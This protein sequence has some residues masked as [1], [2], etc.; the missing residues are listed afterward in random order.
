[1]VDLRGMFEEDII[2]MDLTLE[3]YD[4]RINSLYD[5]LMIYEDETMRKEI[6][7]QIKELEKKEKEYIKKYYA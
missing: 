7:A 3:F 6:R 2:K 1:M 5:S 4:Q